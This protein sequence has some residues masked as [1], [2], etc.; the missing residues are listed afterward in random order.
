MQWLIDRARS[1][2]DTMITN[3]MN[4]NRNFN[5]TICRQYDVIV[6][7]I[8]AQSETTEE[9]VKQIDYVEKLHSGELIQLRVTIE[10]S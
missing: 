6:K 2:A 8:S 4:K 3:I 10:S 5:R 9:L 1:L 7:K